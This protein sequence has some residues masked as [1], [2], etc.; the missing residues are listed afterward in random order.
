MTI[1]T[2]CTAVETSLMSNWTINFAVCIASR[3]YLTVR[4]LHELKLSNEYKTSSMVLLNISLFHDLNIVTLV[5]VC[6]YVIKC[7]DVEIILKDIMLTHVMNLDGNN[8]KH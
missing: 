1:Q 6:K 4:C 5:L 8:I 7:K 2:N 3:S